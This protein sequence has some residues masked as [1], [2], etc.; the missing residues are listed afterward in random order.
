V[1]NVSEWKPSTEYQ[2][3][4]DAN[5]RF[6]AEAAT[7]YDE[8]ESCVTDGRLQQGLED[9]LDRAL[10]LLGRP[11]ASLE[12]LDACGGSGNVSL[13]LLRR[14]VNVTLVDISPELQ[15]IF[16]RKC[17]AEGFVPNVAS[18]EIGTF[19]LGS[20]RAFDLIVFSSA[21]HHL[22]S[23]EPV[24]AAAFSRLKPG[25]LLLTAFDPTLQ[26]GLGQ[27]VRLLQRAEYVL[28]K[29]VSH[30]RDVPAALL[31]RIRRLASGVSPNDKA[32]AV[33][34]TSTAGMLAEYHVERGI[35]DLALAR[36][37]EEIG[38]EVAVHIRDVESR[39][40]LTRWLIERYGSATHFRLVLRRPS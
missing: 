22:E 4:A 2:R 16:R 31:R 25:G 21:L 33:L 20:D 18:A 10:A 9:H 3:I 19:L 39:Y 29:L 37:M 27:S 15:A 35:D 12:A 38:F 24:L 40:R 5:R 23:I 32:H 34:D 28:F 1:H 13:K 11:A 17:L 8:T 14:G 36:S 6:Y 26:S 7:Q 30:T